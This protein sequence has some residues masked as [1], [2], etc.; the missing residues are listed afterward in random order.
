V[1]DRL[2]AAVVDAVAD[3]I[4]LTDEEIKPRPEFATAVNIDYVLGLATRGDRMLILLDIERLI[5]GEELG[6]F[7]QEAA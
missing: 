2:V 4:A 5:C 6:L 7:D 1:R 3:V